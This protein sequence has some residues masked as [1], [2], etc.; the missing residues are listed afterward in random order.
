MVF[1]TDCRRLPQRARLP[2]PARY[3][4]VGDSVHRRQ[5]QQPVGQVLV[6]Q[7]LADHGLDTYNLAYHGGNLAD[8][9]AYIRGFRTRHGDDFR[10]LLFLF[11]GNDF[12][13]SRGRNPGLAG[14][15]TASATTGC[16]RIS[17]PTG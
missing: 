1:H 10:A 7:L 5:Q 9:A 16:S 14:A 3:V 12:E 11:E 6:A 4:L 2:R 15:A 17:T 8:Y 13:D